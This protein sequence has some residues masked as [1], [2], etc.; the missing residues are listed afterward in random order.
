MNNAGIEPAYRD[1]REKTMRI[2]A[3]SYSVGGQ[4]VG[5]SDLSSGNAG[6]VYRSDEVDIYPCLTCSNDY[7]VGSI[8]TGEWLAYSIYVPKTGLYD[9]DFLVGAIDATGRIQLLV[10]GQPV[11]SPAEVPNTGSWDT[12]GSAKLSG[13][14]LTQGPHV[15]RTAFTGTFSF[16]YFT[17][18]SR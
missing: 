15:I 18:T 3:E 5:Y 12:Y 6:G 10:D 16:D 7:T 17:M 8:Q 2:E 9:F 13:V 11:G 4:D 1:I 14:Q